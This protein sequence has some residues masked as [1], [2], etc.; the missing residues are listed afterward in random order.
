MVT[1]TDSVLVLSYYY[2]Y[3]H[4]RQFD[5]RRSMTITMC[6]D[7]NIRRLYH[8]NILR[9]EYIGNIIV[10]SNLYSLYTNIILYHIL[11]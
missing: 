10:T 3:Y 4:H 1:A 2:Y 9:P 6:L 7:N 11:L 5:L 8:N